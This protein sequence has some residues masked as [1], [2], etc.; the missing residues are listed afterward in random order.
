MISGSL[1]LIG[2][3]NSTQPIAKQI[4]LPKKEITTGQAARILVKFMTTHPEIL[5]LDEG[6]VTLLAIHQA[7]PCK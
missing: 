4:C 7:Y 6:V 3:V 2:V 1:S 5:N